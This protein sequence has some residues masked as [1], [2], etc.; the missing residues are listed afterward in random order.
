MPIIDC[1]YLIAPSDSNICEVWHSDEEDV[2]SDRANAWPEVGNLQ[3]ALY[4]A[5]PHQYG[6]KK[7][8]NRNRSRNNNNK[9]NNKKGP[10][11][12]DVTHLTRSGQPYQK[13][14]ITNE[15]SNPTTSPPSKDKG[16]AV[17]EEPTPASTSTPSE[18]API[19]S[20]S[21]P[22]K[23]DVLQKQLLKTRADISIWQILQDSAEHR[24]A[25]IE[26]L[27]RVDPASDTTPNQI[28]NLVTKEWLTDA[29]TFSEKNLPSF[30]ANHNLALYINVECKK[31]TLPV[32][33]IDNGSAVN[34]L[35]LI[36]A[37]KLGLTDAEFT[38]CDSG[39]KAF[40]GTRR[41]VK[42]TVSLHIRTCP[43]ERKAEFQVIDI[44]PSYNMLLG[45]P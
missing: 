10:T 36:T 21:G 25:F 27:Q 15:P 40:D 42:G 39:V 6:N 41:A 24:Q 23:E 13:A 12:E 37:K 22:L 43:I 33:L 8:N 4:S 32:F 11:N 31:K 45:R 34:V 16:K 3:K 28:I 19:I 5:V 20:P 2:W 17:V 9:N 1:S 14:P 18:P 30:G 44:T 29:I 7:P 35:P 26:A 38:P